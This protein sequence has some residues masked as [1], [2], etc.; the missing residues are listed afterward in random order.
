MRVSKG[1]A[2]GKTRPLPQRI[3]GTAIGTYN[4]LQ[5]LG[6]FTRRAQ[7]RRGAI[8]HPPNPFLQLQ[9]FNILR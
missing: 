9:V 2:A 7:S 8:N 3:G 4:S 5:T 6:Q 1:S